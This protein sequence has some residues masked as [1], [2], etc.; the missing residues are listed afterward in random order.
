MEPIEAKIRMQA[1]KEQGMRGTKEAQ[2][3]YLMMISQGACETA[4]PASG[5]LGHQSAAATPLHD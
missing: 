4:S 3:S 1:G 5:L 2:E